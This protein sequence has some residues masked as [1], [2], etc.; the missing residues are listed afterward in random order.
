MGRG[1][2]VSWGDCIFKII[3]IIIKFQIKTRLRG[4]KKKPRGD[5]I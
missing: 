3:I 4:K 5:C 1:Q 2:V